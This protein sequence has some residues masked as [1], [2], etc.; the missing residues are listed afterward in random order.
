[1]TPDRRKQVARI[2]RSELAT[3]DWPAGGAL[4]G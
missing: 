3:C 2:I 4:A 1:M